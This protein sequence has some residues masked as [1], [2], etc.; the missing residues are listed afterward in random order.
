MNKKR[1]IALLLTCVM[2]LPL[3]PG[4]SITGLATEEGESI[5]TLHIEKTNL[6]F[7][8]NVQIIYAVKVTNASPSALPESDFGMLY[9]TSPQTSYELGKEEHRT[10]TSG[11]IMIDKET[12]YAFEYKELS[13]KQMTD[14]IYTRAYLRV[15]GEVY[16]SE[17]QKYSVLQYAY[18]KLGRTAVGTESNELKELLMDMLDYGASAQKNFNYKTDRLANGDFYK[19]TLTNGTFPHDGMNVS[20]VSKAAGA[21]IT[22]AE[23]N[24]EGVPFAFWMSEEGEIISKE[25]TATIYPEKNGTYTAVYSTEKIPAIYSDEALSVNAIPCKIDFAPDESYYQNYRYFAMQA[26]IE[27]TAGGRL[28][29]CWIGG[30]DNATAFLIATYSDDKGETWEDIQFVIDPHNDDLPLVRNV[31]I[32]CFWQDPLGRLWLFYQQSLGMYDGE[33]ANLA[34]VCENPDDETPVWSEPQYVSIGASLKKPIVTKNGEWL[35]PVSIWERE[36]PIN[37]PLQNEYAE[38]DEI[39]GA[40]VYAS[41]DQ[42]ATWEYR[43]G[44]NFTNHRF[45]EHSIVELDDGRIM[46]YSRC[47][48]EIRKSYSS[49]GGRTWTAEEIAFPHVDSLAM[50]R[51]LPSGNLLLIKHGTSMTEATDIRRDLAAFISRDG[52]ETWEGGLLL[53]SGKYVSYPDIAIGADG[54][55]YVQ[56]DQYRSSAALILLAR[57]TEEEVL[58]GTISK[59]GSALRQ[60]IKDTAGIKGHPVVMD[61]GAPFGGSGTSNDPYTIRNADQ[62]QYLIAQVAGGNTFEGMYIALTADID[63]GGIELQPVGFILQKDEYS[64]PFRGNFNGNDHTV[65]NFT[66]NAHYMYCRG[67]FGYMDMGSVQHIKVDNAL[68]RG[69]TNIGAIV[70]SIK[71]TSGNRSKVQ[72]CTVGENV[73]VIGYQRVG[74]IIG[75]AENYVT[76]Q[77]CVNNATVTAPFAGGDNEINIG[78]IVGFINNRIHMDHCTNNGTVTVRHAGNTAH[79][80]GITS[81]GNKCT[82]VSCINNGDVIADDCTAQINIAGIA[83]WQNN[84]TFQNCENHGTV[85]AKGLAGINAGGVIAYYGKDNSTANTLLDS[86]SDGEMYIKHYGQNSEINVGGLVGRASATS[87]DTTSYI[88]GSV[89]MTVPQVT[90]PTGKTYVGSFIGKYVADSMTFEGNYAASGRTVGKSSAVSDVSHICTVDATAAQNRI[91]ELKNN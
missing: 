85:Y 29:S 34:I 30:G 20:L 28:W 59:E 61:E 67:L 45:N 10:P 69:N 27:A 83:A 53:D 54:T 40:R 65:S 43:G 18:N 52:G 91:D 55:I 63:F 56:Y 71:G 41:T 86:Y 21:T 78:G 8:D 26:S 60:T 3:L 82:I 35:L 25:C 33:G 62:W 84:N 1:L 12:F 66:M 38:L 49:D 42:G 23:T 64:S 76:I 6:Q 22:A 14:D 13:A 36:H 87:G 79:I 80:G 31:H 46:M 72:H 50:I 81:N 68:I 4:L 58:A 37:K 19:V 16:Y 17:V 39:R 77:N 57:F 47:K 7:E 90:S 44:V 88:K 15:N 5:P 32:G 9:W 51:T 2:L 11:A 24:A 89:S 48:T 70:G 75:N 73:T 74:G